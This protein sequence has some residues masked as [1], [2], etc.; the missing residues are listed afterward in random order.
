[1]KVIM[2]ILAIA[3]GWLLQCANDT[4]SSVADSIQTPVVT[5]QPV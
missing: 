3:L 1:M 2:L 5:T 4:P